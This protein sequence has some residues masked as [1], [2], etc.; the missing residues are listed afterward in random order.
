[1]RKTFS[2][3]NTLVLKK[4]E[5]VDNQSEYIQEL[6]LKDIL[7]GNGVEFEKSINDTLDQLT[8]QIES[9]RNKVNKR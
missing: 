7:S 6:I 8:M 9:I 4:L 3:T 5:Q 2:I 1:M